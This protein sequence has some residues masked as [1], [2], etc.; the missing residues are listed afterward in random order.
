MLGLEKIGAEIDLRH[1]CKLPD[2]NS[3]FAFSSSTI[4]EN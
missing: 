2:H 4:L 1:V 3:G